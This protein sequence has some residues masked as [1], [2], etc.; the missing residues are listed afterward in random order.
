M[1]WGSA[2]VLVVWFV[3]NILESFRAVRAYATH[4][5][6]LDVFECWIL[7]PVRLF[8]VIFLSFGTFFLLVRLDMWHARNT[9]QYDSFNI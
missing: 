4:F 7:V 6:L 1:F 5:L 8:L 2:A 3:E 9:F